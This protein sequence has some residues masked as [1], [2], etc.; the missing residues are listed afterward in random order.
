M[1][2]KAG[3]LKDQ[4]GWQTFSQ[5]KEKRENTQITRIRNKKEHMTTDITEI[6]KGYKGI[7]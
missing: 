6:K 5:I 1:K 4:R 2:L 7:L 3:S